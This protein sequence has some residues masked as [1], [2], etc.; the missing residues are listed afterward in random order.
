M[1][2]FEGQF[3]VKVTLIGKYEHKTTSTSHLN[4]NIL[5]FERWE[6]NHCLNPHIFWNIGFY[7]SRRYLNSV[8][9]DVSLT[10]FII[11]SIC[12]RFFLYCPNRIYTMD[13]L[14]STE[15][16]KNPF[17]DVIGNLFGADSV[18]CC[19]KLVQKSTGTTK[20]MKCH[21]KL[22]SAWSSVFAAMFNGCWDGDKNGIAIEDASYEEFKTFIDYFYL[23]KIELNANNV[24]EIFYLAHKYD[25]RELEAICSTFVSKHLCVENAVRYCGMAIRFGHSDLKAKCIELVATDTENILKSGEFRQC[26]KNTLIEIL[27]L[28]VRTCKE[29]VV[30][31]A[32]I[33]YAKT[34]CRYNNIDESDPKNLRAEL[35]E[36]FKL[37][38]FIEMDRADLFERY[39][40]VKSMFTRDEIEDL[41]GHFIQVKKINA[42]TRYKLVEMATHNQS[43]KEEII[44]EFDYA[45]YG[46]FRRTAFDVDFELSHSM[47]LKGVTISHPSLSEK[48]MFYSTC[49]AVVEVLRIDFDAIPLTYVSGEIDEEYSRIDFPESVY[50]KPGVRY[51]IKI[52]I[53]DEDLDYFYMWERVHIFKETKCKSYEI[54]PLIDSTVAAGKIETVISAMHFISN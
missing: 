53:P 38:R 47:K 54:T 3:F 34:K 24:D 39:E 11:T 52:Y 10:I 25:V 23:G 35:G 51:R 15:S 50:M 41:L 21:R 16:K 18:D 27:G 45:N 13:D 14:S 33:E 31:D 4:A 17:V 19:F 48:Y 6:K 42:D 43:Q 36:G 37:I 7:I 46:S 28:K 1:K 8:S 32:C 2:R 20:E 26:D 49:I 22:L 29:H 30:L 12:V 9:S 40:L 5:Q 44:F